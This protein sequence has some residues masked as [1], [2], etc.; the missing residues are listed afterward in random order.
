MINHWNKE[1]KRQGSRSTGKRS[2]KDLKQQIKKVA[3]QEVFLVTSAG[4]KGLDKI[5]RTVLAQSID[6]LY[7]SFPMPMVSTLH[8]EY[9]R[10][11]KKGIKR[12]IASQS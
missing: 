6:D 9:E 2:H 12:F 3:D 10:E 7:N 1:I 11:V 4:E 5:K 8:D